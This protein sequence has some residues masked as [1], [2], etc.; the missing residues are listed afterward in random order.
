[1]IVANNV[2]AH[3]PDINNFVR[4]ISILLKKKGVVTFE[5]PHLLEL[6]KNNQYDTIYH[7]HYS[8]LSLIVVNTIFEKNG[9]KIFDVQQIGTHGGSLRV[10]A[11]KKTYHYYR[12][13]KMFLKLFH[14]KKN[15]N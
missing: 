11:Q 3:V 13:E 7:E 2:L 5:F 10:F 9:L 12:L 14:L 4:G 8:Y 1:M 6:I 15:M